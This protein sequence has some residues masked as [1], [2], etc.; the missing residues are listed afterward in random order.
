[1]G[2]CAVSRLA[3]S[4]A[5]QRSRSPAADNFSD[6]IDYPNGRVQAGCYAAG[7]NDTPELGISALYNVWLNQ[8]NVWLN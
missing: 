7:N 8:N 1:M 2:V 4:L 3:Q 6:L 5:T